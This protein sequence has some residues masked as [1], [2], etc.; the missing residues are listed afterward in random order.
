MSLLESIVHVKPLL[1]IEVTLAALALVFGAI[2]VTVEVYEAVSTRRQIEEQLPVT[3]TESV[4]A[5]SS[6]ASL[7]GAVEELVYRLAPEEAAPEVDVS[8]DGWGTTGTLRVR[9]VYEHPLDLLVFAPS[10]TM[11][12]TAAVP[13]TDVCPAPPC[14]GDGPDS[15]ARS[16]VNGA[17]APPR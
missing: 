5:A 8:V 1:I 15:P 7:R 10:M 4:R 16:E 3:M 9:A 12:A 17:P 14:S 11:E 6:E 2:V 13:W